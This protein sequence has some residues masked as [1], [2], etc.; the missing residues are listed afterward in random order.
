MIKRI[1]HVSIAVRDL[2]SAR[3]F[4]ID[5]LGGT[6]VYS[7]IEEAEGFRWTAI[8]LGSSCGLELVDPVGE[9]SFL[10]RFLDQRGDS[11][12]HVTIQVD[13]AETAR[14]TLEAR[15]V[16]TFGYN[17]DDANWK[18]FYV[19]PKNAFGVLLQ[20][21]E[22]EPKNWGQPEPE[23][24][25]AGAVEVRWVNGV[26]APEVE[27]SDGTARLRMAASEIPDL[28]RRLGDMVDFESS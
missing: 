22:F 19:H 8:V 18:H 10:E 15:G 28:V 11:V 26:D 2:D 7:R 23:V 17:D 4:F 25:G 14:Q 3:D 21:A 6:E 12:H 1:D 16:P 13:D 9:D 5:R 20:F 27:F 24:S